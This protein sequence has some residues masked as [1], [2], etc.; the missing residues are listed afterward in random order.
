MW[1]LWKILKFSLCILYQEFKFKKS[2]LIKVSLLL[3]YKLV[4]TN[5]VRG[6]AYKCVQV[7][8]SKWVSR[9]RTRG[10]CE[11]SIT[12]RQW[13]MLLKDS[14]VLWN[15]G[16]KSKTV[17]HT[18][19]WCPKIKKKYCEGKLCEPHTINNAWWTCAFWRLKATFTILKYSHTIRSCQKY[20]ANNSTN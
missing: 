13:S 5:S 18:K 6:N 1:F 20:S 16:L 4:E 3:V 10:E 2:K 19:D 15:P 11:E 12:H 7:R 8:G 17:A 14:P 9:C